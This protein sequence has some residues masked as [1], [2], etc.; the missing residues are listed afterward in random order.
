[1]SL[2]DGI[3]GTPI[4]KWELTYMVTDV[5]LTPETGHVVAE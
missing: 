4:D 5:V 3:V 2:W 1:M